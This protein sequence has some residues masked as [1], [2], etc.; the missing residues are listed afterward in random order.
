M[1]EL[2][3]AETVARELD[4]QVGGRRLGEVWVGRADVI[5]GSGAPLDTALPGRRVVRVHRRGKRV[6]LELRPAGS[7]VFHMG[8]SGR[9]IV[10][11]ARR[12]VE[13]HTHLRLGIAGTRREVRF[14]DPRRFGGVWLLADGALSVDRPLRELGPEPLTLTR[15]GFRNLLRRRR[16][17]KALLMDQYAIAGLGNIY[18][19]ES[20]HAARIHPL[21]RADL[22]RADEADRL[23]RAIKSTLRQAIRFN[24]TTFRSY[25][26]ANGDAGSFQRR[27]KVYQRE[28][29]PCRRCGR[30]IARWLIAGRSTFFCATCQPRGDNRRGSASPHPCAKAPR[31]GGRVGARSPD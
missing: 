19:D 11:P 25:R 16:Q 7:L 24:G 3:E 21:R 30:T 8:M 1:P 22:L 20:L 6:V 4:R 2:P 28:G 10:C 15:T 13:R 5:H 27:L 31:P 23:L 9:V 12:E 26:Q 14:V 29:E 18:C 17:V